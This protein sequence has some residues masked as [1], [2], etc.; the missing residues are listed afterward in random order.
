MCMTVTNHL[1]RK[2][3]WINKECLLRRPPYFWRG[4][5][6]VKDS[7]KLRLS[8]AHKLSLNKKLHFS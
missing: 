1:G 6:V 8:S 2:F 3:Y 7:T 5:L 4:M